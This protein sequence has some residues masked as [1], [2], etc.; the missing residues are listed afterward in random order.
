MAQT[1]DAIASYTF[2]SSG[3]SYVFNSIPSTYTDLILVESTLYT[4]TSGQ[5]V[6]QFNSD[7]SGSGTNYSVTYVRGDGTNATSSRYSNLSG[8][9]AS[10]GVGSGTSSVPLVCVR[11]IMNY[12]NATTYKT[13]LQR[14]SSNGYVYASVGLWRATAQ[15]ITSITVSSSGDS[16]AAGSSMTLYG[17]KSA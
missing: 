15:A 16:F 3:T 7:T 9:G 4:P 6:I 10:P 14:S 12:A 2:G 11:H 17:V 13:F 1:Y 8:V 5:S